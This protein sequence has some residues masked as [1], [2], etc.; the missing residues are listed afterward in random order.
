MSNFSDNNIRIVQPGPMT[1]VQ[2]RGRAGYQQLGVSVSGAVDV[3]SL[4]IGNRLVGN[5]KK[6]AGLEVLLGGLVIEFLGD[7]KSVV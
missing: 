4:D 6:S 3:E 5:H 1:L 7:R 2:D